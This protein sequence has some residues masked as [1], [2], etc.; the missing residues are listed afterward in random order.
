[1]ATA[2]TL[3]EVMNASRGPSASHAL[4][5]QSRVKPRGGHDSDVAELNDRITTTTSGRY[6]NARPSHVKIRNAHCAIGLRFIGLSKSRWPAHRSS[7]ACSFD[8]DTR[9][10]T[11][12]RIGQ[13][14]NAAAS[15]WFG[16]S[17]VRAI[18]LPISWVV[19]PTMFGMM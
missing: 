15:G 17:N 8:I 3:I 13:S 6:R 16:A 10:T 1:M 14:V 19:P 9:Y 12:M 4:L 7:K 5:H 2:A 18:R 11:M